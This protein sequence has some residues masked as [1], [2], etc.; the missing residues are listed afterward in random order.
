M[1]ARSALMLLTTIF[2]AFGVRPG[3]AQDTRPQAVISAQIDAFRAGDFDTAFDFASPSIQ[4]IFGNVDRFELMV[5]NGYPMVVD[6][7][8]TRFLEAREIGGRLWQ[9]VLL[10]DRAGRGHVL[11]YQMVDSENG[12]KINAVQILQAPGPEA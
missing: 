5:R 10:R 7:A 4:R 11:D 9:K 6:P 12:W 2:L 8:Q 3:L 1:F